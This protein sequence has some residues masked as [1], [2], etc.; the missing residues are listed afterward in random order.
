MRLNKKTL[1]A[2]IMSLSLTAPSAAALISKP[3]GCHYIRNDEIESKNL[4]ALLLRIQELEH[5]RDAYISKE[6]AEVCGIISS[7]IKEIDRVRNVT[8]EQVA[9]VCSDS[10]NYNANRKLVLSRIDE[11]KTLLRNNEIRLS[12]LSLRPSADS[13]EIRQLRISSANLSN[14]IGYWTK[15]KDCLNRR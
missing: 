13:E 8:L 5:A 14:T 9:N 3:E 4:T 10:N 12:R 1:A 7:D 6:E 15:I 11:T 2:I